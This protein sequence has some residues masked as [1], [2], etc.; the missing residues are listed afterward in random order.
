MWFGPPCS[1]GS[2]G[3]GEFVREDHFI[4][5]ARDEGKVSELGLAQVGVKDIAVGINPLHSLDLHEL[6]EACSFVCVWQDH[7]PFAHG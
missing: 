2:Q 5:D 4:A 6:G 3:F 7:A 1:G